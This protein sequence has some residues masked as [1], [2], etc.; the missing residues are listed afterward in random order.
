V[1]LATLN[2]L[3]FFRDPR[4]TIRFCFLPVPTSDS[5]VDPHR[6]LFVHDRATLDASGV[7]FTLHRTLLQIATQVSAVIPGTTAAGIFRRLWDTQNPAP[8]VVASGAHCD[9]D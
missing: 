3:E 2:R 9:D 5:E 8:G 7:D 1:R 4:A 6:S